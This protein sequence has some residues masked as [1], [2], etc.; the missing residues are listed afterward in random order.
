[1]HIAQMLGR[2]DDLG[3]ASSLGN[4]AK[5]R[6]SVGLGGGV[7]PKRS[8]SWV[9]GFCYQLNQSRAYQN[10]TEKDDLAQL[11]IAQTQTKQTT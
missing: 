2:F 8:E 7:A 4:R 3:M 1:M 6:R 11:G 5:K 10:P 9:I